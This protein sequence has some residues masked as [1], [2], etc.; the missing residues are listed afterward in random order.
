MD[1]H[2]TSGN[3]KNKSRTL[4]MAFV[5]NTAKVFILCTV[6]ALFVLCAWSLVN[7]IR[8]EPLPVF[9]GAVFGLGL[10]SITMSIMLLHESTCSFL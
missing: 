1:P 10:L 8:H 4:V 2:K 3:G 6:V 5:F 9:N 7:L